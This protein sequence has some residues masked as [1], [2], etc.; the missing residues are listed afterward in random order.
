MFF[1]LLFK[2]VTHIEMKVWRKAT[3]TA[4]DIVLDLSEL[5]NVPRGTSTLKSL[6]KLLPANM[7]F[8]NYSKLK[9]SPDFQNA[10]PSF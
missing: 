4:V 5:P 7:G 10:E 3:E 9:F 8:A 6:V 1:S 2:N